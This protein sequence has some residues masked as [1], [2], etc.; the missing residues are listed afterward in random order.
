MTVLSEPLRTVMIEFAK[1]IFESQ[2]HVPD[3][4]RFDKLITDA[5]GNRTVSFT[6][7]TF[8]QRMRANIEL[9]IRKFDITKDI[10]NP[11]ADLQFTYPSVNYTL[12]SEHIPLSGCRKHSAKK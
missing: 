12:F 3:Y 9:K 1:E 11:P 10:D 5:I 6:W 7:L 4:N 2:K 8:F